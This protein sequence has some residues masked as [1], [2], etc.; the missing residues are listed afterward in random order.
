MSFLFIWF[1]KNFIAVFDVV[2]C[3]YWYFEIKHV[4]KKN[5]KRLSLVYGVLFWFYFFFQLWLLYTDCQ[6]DRPKI[7]LWQMTD[8]IIH[9]ILI[10]LCVIIFL[11]NFFLH[12][13]LYLRFKI[14]CLFYK[15][16]SISIRKRNRLSVNI[17]ESTILCCY[18]C[19]F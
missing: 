6:K 1:I 7:T 9:C 15:N 13:H 10:C 8:R 12:F 2:S 17:L 18:S 4:S 11:Y 16:I 5:V 19:F 14:F 3:N